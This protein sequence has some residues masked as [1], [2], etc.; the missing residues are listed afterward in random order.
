MKHA[1]ILIALVTVGFQP[2]L[3]Q[4]ITNDKGNIVGNNQIVQQERT[5]GSFD[6]LTVDFAM[7]VRITEGDPAKAQVE[8]E[9]NVLPYVTVAVKNGELTIGLSRSAKF[10][11]VEHVTVTIHRA[12]L[13]EIRAKTACGIESD[14]PIKAEKLTVVLDEACTLTTPLA[15]GRL[16]A[17]LE[18]AC[19]LTANGTVNEVRFDLNGASKI[20]AEK[21]IIRKA[22]V[23]LE[24]ASQAT[25]HVTDE[26]SASAEGV[27][28]LRYSGN[29]TVRSQRTGGL[30]KIRRM[31]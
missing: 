22:D 3:G 15:V 16:D 5:V 24:G 6:R 25:L 20:Y 7:K 30:S 4:K 28:T 9:S 11:E 29:P 14:L 27:S 17:R 1:L 31:D 12:A 23:D 13:T 21:L 26:L 8:G 2:S 10:K 19:V 18:A